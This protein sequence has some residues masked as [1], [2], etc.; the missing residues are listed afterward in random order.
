MTKAFYYWGDYYLIPPAFPTLEQFLSSDAIQKEL[1]LQKLNENGCIA[2]YFIREEITEEI[3]LIDAPEEV[4]PA[5][6]ELLSRDEYW[7]KLNQTA[8]EY[9]RECKK[10]KEDT[11]LLANELTLDGMCYEDED[12]IRDQFKDRVDDFWAFFLRTEE[13]LRKLLDEEKPGAEDLLYAQLSFLPGTYL[14]LRKI[15]DRYYVMASSLY[16]QYLSLLLEYLIARAPE[17][18]KTRWE[19]Y[20]YLPQN[21][22]KY[23]PTHEGVNVC[24]H[25]PLV[26]FTPKNADRPRFDVVLKI[27]PFPNTQVDLLRENLLY[28]YSVLGENRFFAALSSLNCDMEYEKETEEFVHIK[29]YSV[30]IQK[31]YMQNLRMYFR[32]FH[33]GEFP[34]KKGQCASRR[35]DDQLV[36]T[37]CDTL[38]Q[39]L[40]SNRPE[41]LKNMNSA[42]GYIGTL[43]LDFGCTIKEYSPLLRAIHD[44]IEDALYTP[45]YIVPFATCYGTNTV[46]VDFILADINKARKAIRSLAP[47]LMRYSATYTETTSY[48]SNTYRADYE[49]GTHE[50]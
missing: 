16:D 1:T 14:S 2:P 44:Q 8:Q 20:P 43:T 3:L 27:Y 31:K 25:A 12:D 47:L 35:K 48:G 19:F 34:L 37:N 28:V 18:L 21:I 17:E 6:V 26:R 32:R 39:A 22:Y 11:S 23:V 40:L 9:C 41:L 29:D 38:T 24:Q 4:C 33:Y 45:G 5:K 36:T 50:A 46:Y 13:E 10:F 7:S 15:K 42:A 49:L 30:E